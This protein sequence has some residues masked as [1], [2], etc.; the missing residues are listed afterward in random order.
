MCAEAL[1]PPTPPPLPPPA[2]APPPP[3]PPP[4]PPLPPASAPPLPPPYPPP[5]SKNV[6]STK[7]KEPEE[8]RPGLGGLDMNAI[9]EA[10]NKLQT[11]PRADSKAKKSDSGECTLHFSI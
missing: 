9:L 1:P 7:S 10:K 8:K 4:P 5:G 6:A 11:R 2:A 3:P